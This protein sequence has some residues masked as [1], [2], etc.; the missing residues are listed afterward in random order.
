[1]SGTMSNIKDW[2]GR[3]EPDYYMMFVKAWI[4]FNA[5]YINAKGQ[6]SGIRNQ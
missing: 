1:M 2:I 3:S 6:I 5:W 4:P